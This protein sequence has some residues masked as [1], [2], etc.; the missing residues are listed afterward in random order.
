MIS[1]LH[2]SDVH[3]GYQ[4]Y[5][6]PERFN[7]FARAFLSAVDFAVEKRA[8]FI[9]ICGDL[10]HKSAIDPKTLLQANEGFERLA[11]AGIQVVAINGNHDKA[12]YSDGISWLH[13]LSFRGHIILL[14]PLF[15]QNGISLDPWN[16]ESG[17]YIDIDDVRIIGIPYLGAATEPVL[18]DFPK[19]LES[20]SKEDIKFSILIGHFG[21]GGV[22]K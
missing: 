19:A 15:L 20:L 16:G 11:N 9:I 6:N 21:L 22:Q 12:R 8:D 14:S 17:S 10:F 5:G 4:Q 18:E 2:I 13:Y 1:F 7:D 3:L